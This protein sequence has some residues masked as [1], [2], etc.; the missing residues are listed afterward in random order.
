VHHPALSAAAELVE[1]QLRGFSGTFSFE[2]ATDEYRVVEG[3]IDRLRRFRIGV[4]WGG[5]ES[6]VLSPARPSRPSAVI[7]ISVGLE[8]AELLI[9]DLRQA[10]EG[11]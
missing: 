10:L 1:R 6:L 8:G 5:V 7:R 9:E 3:V 11:L 2:L 4:S